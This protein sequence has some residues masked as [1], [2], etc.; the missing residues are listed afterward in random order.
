MGTV[1]LVL[2]VSVLVLIVLGT[3]GY[4]LDAFRQDR[5]AKAMA[6]CGIQAPAPAPA[7][8]LVSERDLT[9]LRECYRKGHVYTE[10]ARTDTG[11]ICV[12]CEQFT[13]HYYEDLPFDQD[14]AQLVAEVDA[15]LTRRTA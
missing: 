9:E 11:W 14:A 2:G 8:P 4:F 7:P 12:R 5:I 3:F 6:E 13:P 10:W 15:F 1:G